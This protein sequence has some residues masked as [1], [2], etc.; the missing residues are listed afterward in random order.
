MSKVSEI[1]TA[2]G[3]WVAGCGH[4]G[5]GNVHMAVFQKDDDKRHQVMTELFRAGMDLG[6]AIS[7][8]H[9]LGQTKRQY[10]LDLEDP[11]KVA[12]MRRIKAAFDPNGILNPEIET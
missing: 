1:A 8:E 10:F 3:A 12:L 7:G 9:G 5:D 11:A 6:G 2:H 4:A